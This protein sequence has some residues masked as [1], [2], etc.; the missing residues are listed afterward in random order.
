MFQV[1]CGSIIWQ[2]LKGGK[3]ARRRQ[4]GVTAPA[5]AILGRL[6]SL[7][8]GLPR[9]RDRA[10]VGCGGTWA[11]PQT[12]P[13]VPNAAVP[14]YGPC[15]HDRRRIRSTRCWGSVI[16]QTRTGCCLGRLSLGRFGGSGSNLRPLAPRFHGSFGNRRGPAGDS[17]SL[18]CRPSFFVF[19]SDLRSRAETERLGCDDAAARNTRDIFSP[20]RRRS[21]DAVV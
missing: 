17:S 8:S 19:A 1:Q 3:S 5:I 13:A 9:Y 14:E 12:P 11:D 4:F 15:F 10:L 7:R 21:F 2:S 6:G 16:R 18:R 20:T